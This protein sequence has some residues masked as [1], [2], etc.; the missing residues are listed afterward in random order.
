M[1]ESYRMIWVYYGTCGSGKSLE[2][3]QDVYIRIH[4]LHKNVIA[5][6]PMN[7][8]ML[9][10]KKTDK[11]GNV[12]YKKHG[13]FYYVDNDF[14][15]VKLLVNYAKKFHKSRKESETL[16]VIDECQFFFD[17]R[18]NKRADRRVWMKFFTQHRK[19]GFNIIIVCPTLAL[20]DRQILSMCDY[21]CRHRKVNNAGFIGHLLLLPTFCNTTRW[22]GVPGKEGIMNKHFYV[23]HKKYSNMYDSFK[24]FVD[25][26]DDATDGKYV[27]KQKDVAKN[28]IAASLSA[29]IECV[30]SEDDNQLAE[31]RAALINILDK[32]AGIRLAVCC[33]KTFHEN[34]FQRIWKQLVKRRSFKSSR[35]PRR[36]VA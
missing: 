33:D 31:Q 9:Y 23:F 10:G 8:D 17:P 34:I 12:K 19:L 29:P 25:G 1:G 35:T 26:V 11:K 13:I 7:R 5:N 3:A 14:M 16:L 4:N 27:D 18:D 24:F 28:L 20:I 2:L 22:N 6:F 30:T 36:S 32:I 15:S 21:T